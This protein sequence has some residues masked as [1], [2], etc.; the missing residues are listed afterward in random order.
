[1]S[2]TGTHCGLATTDCLK[3]FGLTGSDV[4]I[5]QMWFTGGNPILHSPI[6]FDVYPIALNGSTLHFDFNLMFGLGD[7]QG[8]I[9]ADSITG[10]SI[11]PQLIG[12]FITTSATGVFAGAWQV[13]ETTDDDFTVNLSRG[14]NLISNVFLHPGTS[15]RGP[16]SSGEIIPNV[17]E[18]SSLALLGSGRLG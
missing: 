7:L 1:M 9:V 6:A 11:A 18:P 13:G 10:S 14:S 16:L 8:T 4:G 17:P 15:T 12:S 2:F 3:G 5:Y